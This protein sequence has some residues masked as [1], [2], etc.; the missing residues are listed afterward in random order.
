M[1]WDDVLGQELP[2]RLFAAHLAAGRVSRA[3]LLAGPQGVGKRRLALEMAKALNCLAEGARPCDACRLCRQIAKGGHPDV[4]V[5]EP[6]GAAGLI[7]IDDVR[8]ILG[9]VALRPYAARVQVVILDGAD[10]LTEE[11]ANSLLKSLEEPSATTHFL[12][13]TAQLAGCLPTIISR[14]QPV[15]CAPLPAQVLAGAL[16]EQAGCAP[17][18]AAAIA[19]LSGGSLSEAMGRAERWEGY[20]RVMERLADARSPRWIQE[21]PETR[22]DVAQLLEGMVAWLTDALALAAGEGGDPAHAAQAEA[23]RSQAA[24]LDVDRG[25]AAAEMLLRLRESLDQFVSPRLI[26]SLARETWLSLLSDDE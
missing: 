12:L 8:H 24:R 14:C 17:E 13:L 7:R 20:R 3:Y 22:E 10:R 2:K 21:P 25:L 18:A 9:R 15:R 19:R 6:S 23:L 11:A 5:V 4:H 26:A 16:R 1:A